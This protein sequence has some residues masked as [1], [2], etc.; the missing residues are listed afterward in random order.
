MGKGR[1]E[2][3]I[4]KKGEG[5]EMRRERRKMGKGEGRG[6]ESVASS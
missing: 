5:E 6:K 3:G 1:K 4:V 2:K